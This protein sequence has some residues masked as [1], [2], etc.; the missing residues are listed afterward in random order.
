METTV[1]GQ[2]LETAAALALGA[3]AGVF[4]DILRVIR[5]R[6]PIKLVTL[7]CDLV[8][9]VAAGLALFVLGMTIG[10]GRQRVLSAALSA[11]GFALYF[12]TLT[13]P[14]TYILEG[15]A[16]LV[17]VFIQLLC[18]PLVFLLKTIKLFSVFS[19]KV[20]NYGLG[21]YIFREKHMIHYAYHMQKTDGRK[22]DVRE[23]SGNNA[24]ASGV[25]GHRRAH[26]DANWSSGRHNESDGETERA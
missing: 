13:R 6:L 25:R 21:W 17:A 10:G 12:L 7:L 15:L 4:Y 8:F 26:L 18:F 24:K 20:F 5:R 3:A 11:A 19:K 1:I 16:D 2:L 9:S 22:G 14:A 23:K